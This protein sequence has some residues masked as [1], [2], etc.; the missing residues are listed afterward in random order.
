MIKDEFCLPTRLRRSL[1]YLP[2]L[3]LLLPVFSSGLF[4]DGANIPS[5][6]RKIYIVTSIAG[7][8]VAG[9]RDGV[10]AEAS[11]K[12]PTGV[13]VSR[14]SNASSGHTLFVAD[15]LNNLIRKIDQDK[16]VTTFA[17]SVEAGLVDASGAKARFNGPD[18]IS[19]SPDGSLYV[20]DS[21]NHRIRRISPD[22][23]VTVVAGGEGKGSFIKDGEATEALFGYPTSVAPD[24][25]G[26][27]YVADRGTHT[28]RKISSGGMVTTVAGNGEAGFRDGRGTEARLRE[29]L[30]VAVAR[31]G[32]IYIADSG[33]NSIR[34][35]S[36]DGEL[37]TIA[38]AIEPGYRDGN[39]L[40]ARFAWPTG[41][42][43]GPRGFIYICDSQNNRI[44]RIT[45][46]GI[47]K[48]IA[49][50]GLTGG[51]LD[52]PGMAAR[53]NF[54]TGI[55]VSPD[56]TIYVADTANNLIRKIE[57]KSVGYAMKATDDSSRL[58]LRVKREE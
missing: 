31:D 22:G 4:A 48:T 3:I 47:V 27:L 9:N 56:G 28:I 13:T 52:G 19:S 51:F 39:G 15:F 21:N 49:G 50:S 7:S 26:N 24:G 29:P 5:S 36:P 18:N 55:D 57:Y 54:P 44:R 16:R 10:D 30:T 8:G 11:F 43:I 45:P 1:R 32:F 42:A 40:E 23:A 37:K 25:R 34:R 14:S 6:V 2:A 41:I 53:F 33:N 38:G 58:A 20:A 46:D 12:W 35:L 17:G